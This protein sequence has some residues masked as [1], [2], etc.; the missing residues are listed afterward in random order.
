MFILAVFHD[1]L[2]FMPTSLS[3]TSSNGHKLGSV[4][5]VLALRRSEACGQGSWAAGPHLCHA[6]NAGS[7]ASLHAIMSDNSVL[8][9]AEIP[10]MC[11]HQGWQCVWLFAH[12]RADIKH[13]AQQAAQ[14]D[15]SDRRFC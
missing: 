3:I 12:I 4:K 10:M 1:H 13:L 11:M 6:A 8:L 2:H 15:I 14:V 7:S 9:S 5:L